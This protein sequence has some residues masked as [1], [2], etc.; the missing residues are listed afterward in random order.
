M[1]HFPRALTALSL[2]ATFTVAAPSAFAA[3]ATAYASFDGI[4][5]VRTTGTASV[6]FT[7]DE[8]LEASGT[9]AGGSDDAVNDAMT[10]D[11][12]F[13]A[14]GSGEAF[15]SGLGGASS[16]ATTASSAL[17]SAFTFLDA[18]MLLDG[19][20]D[21][22]IDVAYS[23]DVD[24]FGNLPWAFANAGI[25]AFNSF[26]AGL[27]EIEVFGSAPGSF[28]SLSGV[29][30]LS[31]FVDVDPLAGAFEDVLTVST[32]ATAAAAPVPLPAA[33]WLLAPAIAG[34][35]RARRKQAA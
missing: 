12:E 15:N 34:L 24:E 6:T 27:V 7:G 9:I 21:I 35:A 33:A 13:A 30:T 25:E 2:A 32:F 11:V 28:D 14:D 8:L 29:L 17:A 1:S 4:S 22:E 20:G 16:F 3:A 26:D 31:F 19:T 18:V 23:L 5:D 10:F